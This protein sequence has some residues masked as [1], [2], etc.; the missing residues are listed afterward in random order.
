MIRPQPTTCMKIISSSPLSVASSSAAARSCARSACEIRK[1]STTSAE[2]T[3]LYSAR[4]HQ[5]V[6]P[7]LRSARRART[8]PSLLPCSRLPRR[9]GTRRARSTR[10]TLTNM[11]VRVMATH[12]MPSLDTPRPPKGR[13]NL[14]SS[15][16][17]VA[18]LRLTSSAGQGYLH[19]TSRPPRGC[20]AGLVVWP[21]WS[22][23]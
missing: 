13:T 19:L 20:E 10:C 2:K 17:N 15:L 23:G 1:R 6:G 8:P 22:R 3:K 16:G 12:A 14:H 11:S 18:L 5:A 4:A 9:P 7:A 21:S